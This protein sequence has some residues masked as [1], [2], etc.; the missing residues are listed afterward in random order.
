[1]AWY[2]TGTVSVTQ[3]SDAVQGAGTDFVSN[4]AKG[5]GFVGPDGV[6][7]EIDQIIDLQTLH[8]AKQYGGVTA[9]GAAYS[10]M[11]TQAYIQQLTQSASALL[12]TFGS[13][14]D[15]YLAG[16]LVGKGLQLKGVLSSSAQLPSS[17]AVGDA[18]LLNASIYGWNAFRGMI[19]RLKAIKVFLVTLLLRILRWEARLQMTLSKLPLIGQRRLKMHKLLVL[20]QLLRR[21]RRR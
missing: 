4:T 12:N 9:Q 3:G 17:P 18:Y 2:K 19:N 8:L 20:Q 7:Y 5:N 13:F 6:V 11:P 1:M 21:P 15:D 14:R 10:I 16:D